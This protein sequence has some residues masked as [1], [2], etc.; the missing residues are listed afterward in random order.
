M[1]IP[2]ELQPALWGAICGAAAVAIVG[3]SWGGWVTSSSAETTTKQKVSAAVVA[4]L[5]PICAENFRRG[6]DA[7]AQ[8]VELKNAK[9]WEQGSFISKGGWAAMPGTATVDSAMASSCA[10]RILASKP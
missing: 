4:A 10:E 7:T 2:D 5:A 3:F 8:L 9:A 1:Q 6:K